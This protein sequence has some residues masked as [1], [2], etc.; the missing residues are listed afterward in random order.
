MKAFIIITVILVLASGA[1]AQPPGQQV[2]ERVQALK[3][4]VDSPIR[5]AP[6][7]AR[8]KSRKPVQTLDFFGLEPNMD[9][10][11]LLPGAGWYTKILGTYLKEEGRLSLAIGAGRVAK[12]KSRWG[13]DEIQSLDIEGFIDFSRGRG[14]ALISKMVLPKNKFDMVL[15]FRNIHNF[16]KPSRDLINRALFDSLKPGGIFAIVDHTKRHMEPFNPETWRRIDPVLIIK[17]VQ[18]Q[19][20]ILEDYST[21]HF[22]PDDELRYDTTRPSIN[23]YSDRFT[24]KFRKPRQMNSSYY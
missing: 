12:Q 15:T 3:E 11:E 21:L 5:N 23:R 18:A 10:L 1:W 8:D 24:L 20:F 19:G 2:S 22:R 13:L 7:R 4:A 14:K 9:V 6:D 16:S 17:E